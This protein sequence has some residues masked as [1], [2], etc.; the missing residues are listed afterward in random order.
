[1]GTTIGRTKAVSLAIAG[2]LALPGFGVVASGP[3]PVPEQYVNEAP[4]EG[5]DWSSARAAL[6]KRLF[7]DRRLSRDSTVACS[8][9]HRADLAFTDGVA[10]AKGVGGQVGPRNSPTLVNRALG[11]TQFWDGRSRTLEDQAPGP[12]TSAAEMGL[13]AK[14]AVARVAA[15]P[16]YRRSFRQAF[17][18]APT[19]ERMAQAIGAYE[20]TIYSVDAPF[21]RF[22]AGEQAALSAPAQRGLKLFG[23]KARCGECH[24][25]ANFTDEQFHALGLQGDAGRGTVTKDPKDQGRF[26][27]PTLREVAR[28]APYMHDGSIATLLEVIDY[29]DRGGAEHPNLDPKMTKLSL[30]REEKE[31]LVA[32]LHSLSGQVVELQMETGEISR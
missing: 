32:F 15:D 16:G 9:C 19:M 11:Q 5:V 7:E 17:G 30:T 22:M 20:R 14:E 24:A 29:Y 28:T 13:D 25:G 18:G 6:G 31:D 1:M 21:D 27:T 12:I 3:A 8:D 23:G 10:R 4:E 26:K 2:A